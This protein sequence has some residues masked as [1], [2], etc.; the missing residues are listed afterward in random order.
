M[1]TDSHSAYILVYP[2]IV[3]LRTS[4]K[5]LKFALPL[6]VKMEEVFYCGIENVI[7]TSTISILL[8]MEN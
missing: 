1:P 5:D 8:R 3:H 7:L 4:L 6:N 2:L